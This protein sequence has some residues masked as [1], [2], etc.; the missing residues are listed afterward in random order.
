MLSLIV[1]MKR[2]SSF[3]LKDSS[4][5]RAQR[6]QLWSGVWSRE[7]DRYM[8]IHMYICSTYQER[9]QKYRNFKV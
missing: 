3:L 1:G 2:I 8:Y 4:R 7:S 5:T 6:H 9:L